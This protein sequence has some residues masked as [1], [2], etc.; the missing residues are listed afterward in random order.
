MFWFR[1]KKTNIQLRTLPQADLSVSR[2]HVSFCL[3]CHTLSY[4]SLILDI[5]AMWECM[6]ETWS[7]R[8]T[9]ELTSGQDHV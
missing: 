8:K 4:L 9:E 3:F 5:L 2:A 7:Q 6:V 1:N